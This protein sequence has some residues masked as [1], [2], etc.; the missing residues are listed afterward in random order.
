MSGYL[1]WQG[2]RPGTMLALQQFAGGGKDAYNDEID[3]LTKR[4]ALRYQMG[5]DAANARKLGAEAAQKELLNTQAGK[6]LAEIA[7]RAQAGGLP[8]GVSPEVLSYGFLNT[9]S[10]DDTM[11]AL[12]GVRNAGY[13]DEAATAARGGDIATLNSLNALITGDQRKPFALSE[14]GLLNQDTGGVQYTSGHTALAAERQAGAREHDAKAAAA[15]L[16]EVSPG[17]SVYSVRGIAAAPNGAPMV[18]APAAPR[19]NKPPSGYEPDPE[20]PGRLR[21]IPGGPG[22]QMTKPLTEG[23]SKAVMFTTRMAAMDD[24]LNASTYD[25]TGKGAAFDR[26]ATSD[27]WTSGM[28]TNWMAS[29]GGQTY[30]NQGKNFVAATLRKESGATITEEEW[31]QGQNLYIPMPG[32]S[33]DVVEQKA[34]NRQLAIE[35]MK[36]EAG[37]AMGRV[38][39]PMPPN[40]QAEAQPAASAGPKPG[41]IEDGHRFKGGDPADPKNWE[42][43][44]APGNPWMA[45]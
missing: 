25:P 2:A 5:S 4:E 32:D 7:A 42:P 30:I 35:G 24:Q 17:A 26:W 11:K 44:S 20:N 15:G 45:R 3:R 36:A 27:G 40:A 41:A 39:V 10:A 9:T 23:Q 38:K 13:Q 29:D 28:L 8:Q 6:V 1:K 31:K 43:V 16:M 33:K 19:S 12:G 14:T 22:D 34:Y 37:D 18:T 21:A